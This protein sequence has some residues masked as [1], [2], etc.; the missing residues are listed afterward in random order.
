MNMTYEKALILA[1]ESFKGKTDKGGSPYILHCFRVSKDVPTNLQIPATLHD[2][3]E[4]CPEWTEEKLLEVGVDSK[5]VDIIKI[6]TH[7]RGETYDEYIDRISESKSAIRIKIADLK[8]NMNLTR[9]PT[10]SNKDLTRLQK[11]H[12]AYN[13]LTSCLNQLT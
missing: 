9:L 13:K 1:E 8:D 3:L 6:L 5:H 7:L 4:D 2:I 12:N 11:Y 10:L